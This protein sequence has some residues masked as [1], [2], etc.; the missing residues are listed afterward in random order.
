MNEASLDTA[1]MSS[2]Q[3]PET[4]ACEVRPRALWPWLVEADSLTARLRARCAGGLCVRVLASAPARLTAD[5]AAWTGRREAFVR[6]THLCCGETPWIYA[7]TI[8]I[9]GSPAEARLRALGDSPLGDGA[10]AEASTWRGGL[11]VAG[12]GA[13]VP[14][15]RRRSVLHIGEERLYIAER[16][17]DGATPWQ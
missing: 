16:F 2:W 11:E 9:D 12:P 3:C 15:W 10:F 5:E 8:A 6:E 1:E 17:L 7:R 4:V 13:A 14:D